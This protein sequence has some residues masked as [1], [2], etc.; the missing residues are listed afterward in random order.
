MK[1]ASSEMLALLDACRAAP[2]DDTPRLILADWL[3]ERGESDRSAFIRAQVELSH[4]T[5]DSVRTR[6]LKDLEKAL[7]VANAEEWVGDL[8]RIAATAGRRSAYPSEV[9]EIS[10]ILDAKHRA[11]RFRRGLVTLQEVPAVNSWP[12]TLD[13]M[14]SGVSPWIECIEASYEDTQE[15]ERCP[16]AR[17]AAGRLNATIKS[18]DRIQGYDTRN[19][20]ILTFT[21]PYTPATWRR[22]VQ[23]ANFTALQSLTVRGV[24]G[25]GLLRELG[26]EEASRLVGLHLDCHSSLQD[27]AT[28]AAKSPFHALASF[29]IGRLNTPALQTLCR[30]EHFRNLQTLNLMANPIGDAGLI[31]L[32]ESPLANTLNS[33]ALQNTGIG[34]AGIAALARSP[35]FDRIHGP[36]LNL[37]MNNIG[38]S[39]L[40]AL[41]GSTSLLRFRELV[42]RENAVGDDGAAALA[43]SPYAANL[44]YLDFWR[45]RLADYG[46][47]AL[48]ESPYLNNVADLSVKE[49]FVTDEGMMALQERYGERAKG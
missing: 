38:D 17:H 46:A 13:A 1:I 26:G 15:F 37:M 25:T 18:S 39:G 20:P 8:Y 9:Q 16:Y 22:F 27:A 45:N 7:F 2:A 40:A 36:S 19:R 43:K 33:L 35:L 29:S 3:E 11:I 24:D 28:I 5:A 48:A 31:A 32:C 12:E 4:P 41:A 34:D 42:L 10:A 49:N 14:R 44:A 47:F 21:E 6:Q 30:S 23:C